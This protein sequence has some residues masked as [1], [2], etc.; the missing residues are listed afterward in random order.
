LGNSPG[1][2]GGDVVTRLRAFALL[3]L[4]F[5]IAA[6]TIPGAARADTRIA[7]VIGNSRYL[8][9]PALPN[10]GNDATDV[11]A[12]LSNI[13][14]K[15]TLQL[16]ASKRQFDQ[17]LEQFARDARAADAALFYFAGHGMQFQG[18]NLLMP[19][20]AEL[21]DEISLR[22]EMTPIDE[23]KEALRASRGVKILVLD[24]CRDNP[25]ADHLMRSIQVSTRDIPRVQGFAR[26]QRAN[27]ILIVYSTQADE[28]ANDGVDRNS[29]FSAALLKELI[30]PGLEV[31]ALFRRVES[32]VFDATSG[33]Q[34]PELSI[35][36][37]PEYYLNQSETDQSV[38]ARIRA[39]ADAATL[40]A[41]IAR[42]PKSFYAPDAA[43]RLDLIASEARK[44]AGADKAGAA[45][46]MTA[47]EAARQK[48][49]QD[50]LDK[51]AQL[52]KDRQQELADRLAAAEAEKARLDDELATAA[53]ERAKAEDEARQ[54][55]SQDA[56][57]R[58]QREAALRSE[59][60]R[61]PASDE[62]KQRLLQKAL[63]DDRARAAA[64]Q[65]ATRATQKVS[66]DAK[67]RA[68]DEQLQAL[69]LRIAELE[70]EVAEARA[71]AEQAA[72]VATEA[73]QAAE[74][75]QQQVA[76]ANSVAT[77]PTATML[78]E[79]RNELR[80]LGC[81]VGGDLGGDSP[82]MKLGVAKYV[83]Y[84]NLA[85]ATPSL[86][87][88]LLDDMKKRRAGL[89]PPECSPHE[90]AVGG[91]CVVKTC[92]AGEA[93]SRAGA[94]VR[95]AP[96]PTPR[97]IAARAPRPQPTEATRARTSASGHC[98]SFNGNQY[99]E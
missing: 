97:V 98:L 51:A 77:T 17:A 93:L 58:A 41:F 43:A 86:D 82:E 46:P 12:A 31:G 79:I 99:C 70:A 72:H 6:S 9:T 71:Q 60:E 37:V 65:E 57:D 29:P 21:S 39:T 96:A 92:P 81:Y 52:A 27:G 25:L 74:K 18:R 15:V 40:K 62:E 73:R 64:E 14:F 61:S 91:Q 84:A 59:I 3:L 1:L 66:E 49:R 80:R 16:D 10:P 36:M 7:L 55:A 35:S 90:V 19:V 20:D 2:R 42:Y 22:Y 69:R 75:A 53:Q 47:D 89:C 67:A 56:L 45:S 38:W 76:V 11:A 30:E 48:A 13:G 95:P 85:N 44:Q 87:Q 94:C 32:D 26:D 28:V 78:P 54:R 24:S 83:R 34:S 88:L 33:R 50:D 8:H 63:D 4:V 5:S 23:V 68:V